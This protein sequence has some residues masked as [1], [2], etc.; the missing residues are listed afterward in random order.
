MWTYF[1]HELSRIGKVNQIVCGWVDY[2]YH[3]VSSDSYTLSTLDSQQHTPVIQLSSAVAF[4][5]QHCLIHVTDDKNLLFQEMTTR[6]Y[7]KHYAIC[8]FTKDGNPNDL[9]DY[10][11]M[12]QVNHIEHSPDLRHSVVQAIGLFRLRIN[13][14]ST[15]EEG[16]YVGDITRFDDCN[17]NDV[18]GGDA[19]GIGYSGD[20][21][22]DLDFDVQRKQWIMPAT[23][24]STATNSTVPRP[25]AM[26]SSSTV[27][28]NNS[29]QAIRP[30]PCSMR[31][32]SSAPNNIPT[33]NKTIPGSVNRRTW[34]STMNFGG[35][36]PP[37]PPPLL[38]A[39][40][41][42]S[43]FYFKLIKKASSPISNAIPNINVLFN[44]EIHP[45]LVQYL[46]A[47]ANHVWIMQYD[48]YLQ[49]SDREPVIWWIA[50]VLPFNQE[51]KIHLLSLSTLR[52]RIMVIYQWFDKLQQQ[53][54]QYQS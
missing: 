10:G 13:S 50:N 51:E 49:Q 28:A 8:L 39:T 4:P 17:Y 29:K 19:H 23:N 37:S 30:R 38:P 7:Q 52:E 9:Y 15:D 22:F 45:R 18:D 46:S 43:Q 54:Q 34:A 26:S 25:I 11:I 21:Y 20:D 40:I 36:K 24:N 35:S 5:G 41:N 12:L 31:L 47:T 16:C 48:W 33:F 44:Q 6:P 42:T 27:T 3:H 1:L 14:L 32:S 2:I 53:Q